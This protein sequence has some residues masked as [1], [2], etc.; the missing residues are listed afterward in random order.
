M[1]LFTSEYRDVATHPAW[2]DETANIPCTK[3]SRYSDTA[4]FT[5]K[6]ANSKQA[7]AYRCFD[8]AIFVECKALANSMSDIRGVILAGKVYR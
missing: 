1:S 8:C 3:D 7:L 4:Q 2:D 5:H 6:D